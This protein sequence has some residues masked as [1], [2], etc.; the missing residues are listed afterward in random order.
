MELTYNKTK[1]ES[2]RIFSTTENTSS[3]E[4]KIINGLVDVIERQAREYKFLS[5][6][7]DIEQDTVKCLEKEKDSLKTQVWE[8]GW[9][10]DL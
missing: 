2:S 6:A 5:M 1:N 4:D 8:A 10:D 9:G 3:L 7:Y